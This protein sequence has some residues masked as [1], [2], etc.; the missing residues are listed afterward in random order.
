LLKQEKE[1]QDACLAGYA[2]SLNIAAT[3]F[4]IVQTS[5]ELKK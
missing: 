2:K 3:P 4:F 5:L 1:A